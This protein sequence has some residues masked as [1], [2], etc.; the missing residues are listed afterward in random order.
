ML[1]ILSLL[2]LLMVA[3][4]AAS[5]GVDRVQDFHHDG[6]DHQYFLHIPNSLPDKAPLLIALQGLGGDAARLR[7]GLGFNRY[8]DE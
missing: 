2:C 6:V 4:S 5:I 8:A 7:H 1:R 3:S